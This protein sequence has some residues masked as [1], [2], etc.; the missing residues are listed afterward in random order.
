MTKR[1][2]AYRRNFSSPPD[3]SEPRPRGVPMGLRP[4][5]DRASSEPRPSRS[6]PWLCFMGAVT[7]SGLVRIS[8]PGYS[9]G[10]SPLPAVGAPG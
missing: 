8:K 3:R 9:G 4:T 1:Q 6:G 5:K 10:R 7:G 2:A